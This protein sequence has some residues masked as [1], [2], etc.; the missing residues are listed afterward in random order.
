MTIFLQHLCIYWACSG[1]SMNVQ[2]MSLPRPPLTANYLL[3]LFLFNCNSSLQPLV[4]LSTSFP[5]PT[6]YFEKISNLLFKAIIVQSTPL[7]PS[8]MFTYCHLLP[9][10]LFLLFFLH[11]YTLFIESFESKLE[12]SWHFALKYFSTY[13]LRTRAFSY[14]TTNHFA[15][16][17]CN[18]YERMISNLDI[19]FIYTFSPLCKLCPW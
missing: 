15:P 19:R 5:P 3:H 9:H 14:I 6:V 12:T 4:L 10:L 17:K 7:Y 2:K 1:C 8:P 18:M 16:E 11:Q 13:L